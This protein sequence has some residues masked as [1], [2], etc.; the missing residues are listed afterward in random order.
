MEIFTYFWHQYL[1]VP[2]FNFLVWIYLNYSYYNLGITII[3]STL[4]LRFVLLPFTIL[5]EKGKITTTELAGELDEIKKD[6]A[7][8]PVELKI[9][10]RE[11][12]HKRRVHPWAKAIVLGIQA[13]ALLL[14][15]QIFITG[16]N[17]QDNIQLLYPSIP[18]PDFINTMFLGFNLANQSFSLPALV[19]GYIFAEILIVYWLEK[20]SMTKRE[21]VFTILFPAFVFL[22]LAALPAVKS[23]F[24]LTSLIFS[25]IIA[26]VISL[27]KMVLK[28]N[29]RR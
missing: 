6:Y 9:K 19:A 27:V 20:R 1:Y 5:E 26:M 15:Y 12:L 3:I 7:N 10:F 29:K 13:L 24:V 22:A 16:I 18:R 17:A 11:A 28:P 8:D 2:G 4:L 23:I 25:T 14:L 21:Q